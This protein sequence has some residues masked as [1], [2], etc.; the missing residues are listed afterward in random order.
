MRSVLG[1]AVF[2]GHSL[3][4][5]AA[6]A[7]CSK[8]EPSDTP[9]TA[10]SSAAAPAPTAS[11]QSLKPVAPK[12][13]VPHGDPTTVE[14]AD[15]KACLAKTPFASF[16]C[17]NEKGKAKAGPATGKPRKELCYLLQQCIYE[18]DCAA[19]DPVDCYCGT[20]GQACEKGEGNGSCRAPVENAVETN[21][22]FAVGKRFG[23]P[24]F[25]GGVAMT[26]IDGSRAACGVICGSR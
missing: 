5:S 3:L 16:D 2:L 15:C 20:S 19:K 26:R 9:L 18:T 21:D 13:W 11:A 1:Q 17:A 23:D 24:A 7:A 14:T 8:P 10:A 25:A 12:P 6:F 22:F 4:M